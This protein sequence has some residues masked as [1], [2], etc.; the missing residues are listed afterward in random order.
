[1]DVGS[2]G[3]ALIWYQTLQRLWPAARFDA[4]AL[5][6]TDLACLL[7]KSKEVP[8]GTTQSVN[9]ALKERGL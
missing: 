4:F 5:V 9:A 3:A 8:V 2:D 7:T 1:M 6:V